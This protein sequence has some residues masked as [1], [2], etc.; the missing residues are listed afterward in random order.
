[1]NLLDRSGEFE[2]DA[3]KVF[4]G[5]WRAQMK[6]LHTVKASVIHAVS[7]LTQYSAKIC[8][9]QIQPSLSSKNAIS[10]KA[11]LFPVAAFL[12]HRPDNRQNR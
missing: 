8:D 2:R 3:I 10:V 6:R 11:V 1:M 12:G 4:H 9:I 7:G 5:D